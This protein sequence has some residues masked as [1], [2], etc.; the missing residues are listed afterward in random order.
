[1][2]EKNV[3]DKK[4]KVFVP[5]GAPGDDPNLLISINGKNYVLPRGKTSEVPA[6]VAA[7]FHRSEKAQERF[8]AIVA[9]KRSK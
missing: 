3:K 4:E 1:M 2:E 6:F 5:K 9:S 8:D 7:E